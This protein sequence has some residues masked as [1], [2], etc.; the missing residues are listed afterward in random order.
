QVYELVA[1]HFFACCSR[2]AV[3]HQTTV[4]ANCGGE[5]FSTTGLMIT[6]RNWLDIYDPWERWNA[7]SIPTFHE[8][9]EFVPSA[10]EMTEGRTEPPPYLSESDLIAEMDRHGIG[11]DATIAEHIKKIQERNYAAKDANSRFF[12]SSLGLALVEG[13][14]DMGFQMSK[15]ALRASMEQDCDKISRGE[16]DRAQV[17]RRC[18]DTMRR[19][20]CTVIEQATKLDAAVS[21]RFA[22]LGAVG[23]ASRMAPGGASFA[24]CGA[25]AYL[26]DLKVS[27]NG[28]ARSLFCSTCARGLLL[29][30]KG[31]ISLLQPDVACMICGF[32]VLEVTTGNGYTGNGYTFCPHCFNNPPAEH[33]GK[34]GTQFRCFNCA[35]DCPLAKRAPGEDTPV[36]PCRRSSCGSAMTLRKG[37]TGSFMLSCKSGLAC[38]GVL[39]LPK[40]AT[41]VAVSDDTCATCSLGGSGGGGGGEVRKLKITFQRSRIP[42]HIPTELLA[43]PYCD[44]T[45]NELLDMD[46]AVRGVAP[47]K[48]RAVRAAVP[49]AGPHATSGSGCGGIGSYGGCN[50]GGVS[51]R[52][53][54][55]ASRAGRGADAS[56]GGAVA[57]AGSAT[58]RKRREPE[59]NNA[60]N[61]PGHSEPCRRL[62]VQK[63]GPNKGR[64]FFKCAKP[65][66]SDPC[67]FFQWADENDN[68]GGPSSGFGGG[69][70]GGGETQ[71]QPNGNARASSGGPERRCPGHD[72]PCVL[73]TVRKEGRNT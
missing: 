49:Q 53:G 4:R 18:I 50:G 19:V 38:Q 30:S 39:W 43:C 5:E 70:G 9:Q 57:G 25:C 17:V 40:A 55:G 66:D 54:A 58:R 71:W 59:G 61:C 28:G 26:M 24:A 29:P 6:E 21:A 37:R 45:L 44:D 11:T 3:G 20:F 2:D 62:I 67:E 31:E 51:S 27:D 46:G 23:G 13:Y 36:A 33:G 68:G 69:G 1:K 34:A 48:K 56:G 60:P 72:E 63:E 42:P 47:P 22:P 7:R 41:A 52:G 14:D 65:A 32:Q 35:A 15:P 73:R 8:G 64:E 12:P 10:L 16:A